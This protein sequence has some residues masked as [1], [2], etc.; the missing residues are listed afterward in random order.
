MRYIH[1]TTGTM[2]FVIVVFAALF[3]GVSVFMPLFMTYYGVSVSVVG[4]LPSL[5]YAGEAIAQVITSVIAERVSK[6]MLGAAVFAA[7]ICFVFIESLRPPF[8]LMCALFLLFGVCSGMLAFSCNAF[9]AKAYGEDR[10]RFLSLV[11]VA[12]YCGS[13]IGPAI[14]TY[15]LENGMPWW[16]IYLFSG[17][18]GALTAIIFLGVVLS[19]RRAVVE[20]SAEMRAN[21]PSSAFAL[22]AMAGRGKLILL[23]LCGFLYLGYQISLMS[24]LPTYMLEALRAPSDVAGYAATL[25][26][27]GMSAGMAL[28][29]I[30]GKRFSARRVMICG[31]LAG[32]AFLTVGLLSG[33]AIALICM[34][35]LA[36]ACTGVLNPLLIDVCCAFYPAYTSSATALI[37][38]SCALG[39]T[40][41]PYVTGVIAE[42]ISFPAAMSLSCVNLVLVALLLLPLS[43]PRERRRSPS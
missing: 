5:M 18:F 13:I 37:C 17:A 25:S 27:A 33:N 16:N 43:S 9:I 26:A 1:L 12:L 31:S 35:T 7:S 42:F 28:F 39:G 41:F 40:I 32:A 34:V 14:P 2:C 36:G 29:S 20:A 22:F 23:C 24:W 30:V 8:A 6:R 3:T 4:W 15:L 21:P 10:G 11:Y 19:T 38:L